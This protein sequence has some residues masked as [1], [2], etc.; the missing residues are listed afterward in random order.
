MSDTRDKKEYETLPV[1]DEALTLGGVE[2]LRVALIGN[3]FYLSVRP[4]FKDPAE[5]GDILAEVT[6]RLGLLYEMGD[7]G[8]GEADAIVAIEEAYATELGAKAVARKRKSRGKPRKQTAR[9][10]RRPA[11]KATRKTAKRK[12]R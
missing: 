10:S 1:P 12:S 8:F 7:T 5:W 11:K 9:Q 3:K 4:G 6:R 2:M